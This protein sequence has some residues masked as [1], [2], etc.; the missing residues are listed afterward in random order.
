[1]NKKDKIEQEIRKTLDQ[2]DNAE[3]LTPNPYFYSRVQ[4]RLEEQ[5]EQ[6]SFFSMVLRPALVTALVAI[7]ISTVVW[8]F[9]GNSSQDKTDSRQQLIEILSDDFGLES[10]QS[11]L[12]FTN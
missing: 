4:A 7:N 5:H 9:S 8:Y 2:F 1:M 11:N 10:E 12:I 6:Q 3:Q